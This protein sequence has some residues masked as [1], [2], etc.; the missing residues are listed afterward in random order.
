MLSCFKGYSE[1]SEET[2]EEKSLS[3]EVSKKDSPWLVQLIANGEVCTVAISPR[4]DSILSGDE[5]GYMILWDVVSGSRRWEV[6]VAE[7]SETFGATFAPDGGT[8]ALG[9]FLG[10]VALFAPANGILVHEFRPS[11]SAVHSEPLKSVQ[12]AACGSVGDV[13]YTPDSKLLASSDG[14]K[15]GKILLWDLVRPRR[16]PRPGGHAQILPRPLAL[17]Y[18]QLANGR[19]PCA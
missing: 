13:A 17:L 6:H 7:E 4:K 16:H 15:G 2:T 3:G 11:G 10:R 12:T 19:G 5:G 18:D 8:I 9:S 1:L 14:L